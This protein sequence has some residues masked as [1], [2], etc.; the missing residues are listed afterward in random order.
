YKNVDYLRVY[1]PQ[2]SELISAS[3]FVKPADNYFLPAPEH[4]QADADLTRIETAVKIDSSSQT[5]ISHEFG[6]TVFGNWVQTDLG[7]TSVVVL[8]Y[9][10]P[11]RLPL[12]ELRQPKSWWDNLKSDLGLPEAM[13][14]YGLLVQKQPGSQ[15]NQFNHQLKF[16]FNPQVVW[17]YPAEYKKNNESWQMTAKIDGDKFFGLVFKE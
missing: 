2:G 14:S 1:L 6:K 16:Q 8:K 4:Y 9:R 5:R 13:A 10:L 11:F 15:A 3:G 7:E 17:Q 12:A